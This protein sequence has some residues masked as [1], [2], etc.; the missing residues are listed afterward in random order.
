MTTRTKNQKNRRDR[1]QYSLITAATAAKNGQL[2]SENSLA[3]FGT[4][5]QTVMARLSVR[6]HTGKCHRGSSYMK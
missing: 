2:N 1:F 3:K 6:L 4:R 5:T